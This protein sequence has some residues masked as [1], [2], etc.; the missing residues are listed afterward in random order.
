M[1]APIWMFEWEI[2]CCQP[3]AVVGT[4]WTAPSVTLVAGDPWWLDFVDPPVP[5]QALRLGV[6][7]LPGEVVARSNGEEPGILSVDGLLLIV[8][9]LDKDGSTRVA[10]RL[11]STAHEMLPFPSQENRGQFDWKGVVTK[12]QGVSY[13]REARG[14]GVAL[15]LVSQRDPVDVASTKEASSHDEFIIHLEVGAKQAT[16]Q[17]GQSSSPG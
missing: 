12:I 5:E 10:G 7:E 6:V 8:P 15:V 13:E 4:E 2:G 3:P 11:V 1:I 9:G 16:D 17:V 14:D